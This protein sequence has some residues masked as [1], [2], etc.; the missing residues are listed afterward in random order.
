MFC[1][2]IAVIPRI[3]SFLVIDKAGVKPVCNGI[4][5]AALGKSANAGAFFHRLIRSS[6]AALP[7]CDPD[8]KCT[9]IPRR[10]V[11]LR[12]SVLKG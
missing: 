4:G 9:R 1:P 10:G 7:L 11:F 2:C 8:A 6:K 12:L 5:I 3:L